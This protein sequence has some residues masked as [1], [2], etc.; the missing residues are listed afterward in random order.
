LSDPAEGV[1]LGQLVLSPAGA[2]FILQADAEKARPG[3]RGT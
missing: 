2:E 1:T 3:T